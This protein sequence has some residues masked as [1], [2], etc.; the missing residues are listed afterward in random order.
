M[1]ESTS[2]ERWLP[3][4][5]HSS[6]EVSDLG[7]VRSVDRFIES[8]EGWRRFTPGC[9]LKPQLRTV[10]QSQPWATPRWT[11][12]LNAHKRRYIA[13]L[14]LEAFVGP[15][16]LGM[17]ACHN[18][19][20]SLNDQLGNLRWDTKSSNMYDKQVHGTDH[21]RNKERCPRGHLLVAPNLRAD[22]LR[23]GGGR[24]CLACRRALSRNRY[25]P[26]DVQ[27]VSDAIYAQ[28]MRSA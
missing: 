11:V 23:R 14:V 18:D 8:I 5:G 2:V 16:P 28:I 22:A 21:Q 10:N 1:D 4:P 24:G 15:R 7:R 17:D 19:G 20:D 26:I 25:R 12:C 6:Y 27:I 13:H 3:V 9:V